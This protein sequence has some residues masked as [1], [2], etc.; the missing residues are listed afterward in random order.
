VAFVPVQG[1]ALSM[2]G[3]SCVLAGVVAAVVYVG[4]RDYVPWMPA[5][6][7]LAVLTVATPLAS[8]EVLGNATNVHSLLLWGL[9]WALLCRPRSRT[10]MWLLTGYA[11]AAALTEVQSIFLL[12]LVLWNRR[13]RSTWSIKAALVLGVAAQAI[14]TLASPRW[15]NGRPRNGVT[16]IVDGWLIN[17]VA[18][19]WV[20]IPH[21]GSVLA[22]VGPLIWLLVLIPASALAVTMWLGTRRQRVAAWLLFGGSLVIWSAGVVVNPAPWYNYATMTPAELQGVW[23]SR[24]GVVPAMM[25]LAQLC[26]AA[27]V[28]RHRLPTRRWRVVAGAMV[29]L[30]FATGSLQATEQLSRRDVGPAWEPQMSAVD[31]TCEV[32][33]THAASVIETLTWRVRVPCRFVNEAGASLDHSTRRS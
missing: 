14:A 20:Q 30:V 27:S 3:I 4:S 5:R 7:A 6:V 13:D 26:V 19:S 16:S 15:S 22:A 8:R 33:D 28:L 29:V 1:W 2:T 9:F 21:L 10:A 24:Y 31:E 23:L 32:P 17:A 12:P 25:L 11:L 18:T